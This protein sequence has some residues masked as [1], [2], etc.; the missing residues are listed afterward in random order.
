MLNLHHIVSDGWSTE[1]LTQ[2]LATLYAAFANG[3]SSPLAELPIQ[4][5][6]YAVWQRK[7][8]QG[9]V[10]EKQLA[11]W[12]SQLSGAPP[13]LELPSDRPRPAKRTHRGVIEP[14]SLPR[15][16]MDALKAVSRAEG[17]TLFMTLLAGFQILLG[18]HAKQKDVVVGTDMA[19]RTRVETEAL[20]GF[21]I[22]LLPMRA[23]LSGDLPFRQFL[24]QVRETALGAYAHQDMPFDKLVEELQP[25]RNA[26]HNPLV[27]VLFVMQNLRRH[28]LQ[29]PG[30]EVGPF[31]VEV[32]SK[33]DM[34][35]FVE[36]AGKELNLNWLYDPDLFD[37]ATIR[38]MFRQYAVLLES[39]AAQPDAKHSVL[40]QKLDEIEQQ[41]RAAHEKEFQEVS[42]RRLKRVKRKS[43]SELEG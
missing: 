29:L 25:E 36:E 14:L 19:N 4:Y 22:N 31:R 12:R 27:Q 16:L 24:G 32:P 11:Y 2:D 9:E 33:F 15:D 39:V 17:V 42:L 18:R 28:S 26:S 43:L 21:F 5:A 34:A 8:L 3:K 35:V 40:M 13:V 41:D 30:L 6:D 23:S 1:I 37:A 38:R 7:W 20:I 10:L